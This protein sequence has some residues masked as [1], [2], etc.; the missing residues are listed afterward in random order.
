MFAF[1]NLENIIFKH[2]IREA[3]YIDLIFKENFKYLIYKNSLNR[4]N[5]D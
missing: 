5:N 3:N 2:D 1:T 4:V